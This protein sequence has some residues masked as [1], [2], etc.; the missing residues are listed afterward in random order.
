MQHQFIQYLSLI[1]VIITL[2]MLASKLKI[3]YPIVLVIGGLIISLIPGLPVV[4]INP[5]LIFIIFLPPLLYEAAWYTSWKDF[6]KWRR[7]ITSF[8]FLIVILTSFVVALV[9][10]SIIPGF[11]MALGLF[12]GRHRISSGCGIC[13]CCAEECESAQKAFC[14]TG[15]RKPDE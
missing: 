3:A 10:S 7:V 13:Q 11:T 2:V 4:E 12:A 9:S 8:A 1:I 5:E 15:R 6:W 14:H